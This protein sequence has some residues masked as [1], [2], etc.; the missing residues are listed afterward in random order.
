MK[1]LLIFLFVLGF[2]TSCKDENPFAR[3]DGKT[4]N[5]DKEVKADR[6]KKNSGDDDYGGKGNWSSQFRTRQNGICM[7]E[8]KDDPNARKICACILEKMEQKFP[9]EADAKTVDEDIADKVIENCEKSFRDDVNDHEGYIK[10]V[11]RN[12]VFEE[13]VNRKSWTSLQRQTAV[14]NCVTE[15]Q[16]VAGFT[17]QQVRTYC[18]CMAGK[19]EQKYSFKEALKLT[20]ADYSTTEWQNAVTDCKSRIY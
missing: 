5:N 7:D 6:D 16:K 4:G 11:E 20:A 18:E 10:T 14:Q 3:K 12:E 15:A 8:Y 2:I 19:L 17:A 9:D 1:K 13:P